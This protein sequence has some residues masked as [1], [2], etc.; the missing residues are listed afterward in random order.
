[1]AIRWHQMTLSRLRVNKSL[2]RLV[3]V[4]AVWS[5][6]FSS[7]SAAFADSPPRIGPVL[8]FGKY[9]EVEGASIGQRT[10]AQFEYVDTPTGETYA[11]CVEKTGDCGL[12]SFTVGAA[13]P[14]GDVLQ[15]GAFASAVLIMGG[16]FPADRVQ[17]AD[18]GVNLKLRLLGWK[19]GG[20]ALSLGG[21]APL[22]EQLLGAYELGSSSVA[23]ATGL[24]GEIAGELWELAGNVR[25]EHGDLWPGGAGPL[26]GSLLVALDMRVSERWHVGGELIGRG[27]LNGAD[28]ESN[29][30]EARLFGSLHRD[31]G[32]VVVNL[33]VG[34]GAAESGNQRLIRFVLSTRFG[35]E[36]P[37]AAV[38]VQG[39]ALVRDEDPD[40]DGLRG[41]DDH[42]PR[43]PEDR[44]GFQDG[45]GCPDTDNDGDRVLDEVDHCPLEPE[46]PDGVADQDGCPE[47]DADEDGIPD[48]DD[49]CPVDKEDGIGQ[50]VDGC[51]FKDRDGDG[52]EDHSDACPDA[53]EDGTPPID[54]GCPLV[55]RD[56]DGIGDAE[57]ACP[58]QPEDQDGISDADGCP[59][60][61][62]DG[63]GVDDSKDR[64]P[65][66][67]GRERRMGCP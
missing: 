59:E 29:R 46:D 26:S 14:V 51:P 38:P 62:Y 40:R 27:K 18:P 66:E 9:L 10:I 44:D 24:N 55:D 58:W 7:V 1:M 16:D 41:A 20:V 30:F 36:R 54:D 45:D 17:L 37:P 4:L 64:C 61:D 57:D 33:G 2:L 43:L 60:D 31:R 19:R 28:G 48:R 25:V 12:S 6:V 35:A 23:L 5:V 53:A 11:F 22:A 56:Q 67:P 63:D 50:A 3:W 52:F 32:S 47:W 65:L 8:A 15:V 34:A 21:T 42:C 39:T 13:L 49:L